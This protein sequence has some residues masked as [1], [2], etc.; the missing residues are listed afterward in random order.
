MK[1][2]RDYIKEYDPAIERLEALMERVQRDAFDAG[3]KAAADQMFEIAYETTARVDKL[4]A[5]ALA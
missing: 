4:T 1:D 5:E 2:V 3:F